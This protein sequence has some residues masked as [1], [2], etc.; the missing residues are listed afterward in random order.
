MKCVE[1]PHFRIAYEPIK[2]ADGGYWDLGLAE[3]KKHDLV[4]DFTT[5]RKLNRLECVEDEKNVAQRRKQL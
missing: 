3:C 1:C 5:R 2:A 4:T